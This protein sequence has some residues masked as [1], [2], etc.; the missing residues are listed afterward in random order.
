[1]QYRRYGDTYV[2][3]IDAGEEILEKL[4]EFCE[5]EDIRL[6]EVNA[7]GAADHA[8]IG[9]FD[10]GK[11]EYFIEELDGFME[12]TSLTGNITRMDG[13]VYIHLHG[14]M[15]DQNHAIHG[16]HI[17][18]ARVGATCEMFI[19]TLPGELCRSRDEI[20]KINLIQF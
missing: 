2:V 4:K 9:V 5:K 10:L 11:H 16:G 20:L 15:A 1:M 17:L 7:L 6:A 13:N 3:R 18:S 14:T 8:S 12:I 19:H